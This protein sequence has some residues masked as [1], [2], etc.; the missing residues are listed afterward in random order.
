MSLLWNAPVAAASAAHLAPVSHP[1][2]RSVFPRVV[3]DEIPENIAGQC[4]NADKRLVG[5]RY[6]FIA[7]T[8]PRYARRSANCFRNFATFGAMTIRQ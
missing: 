4:A 8:A 7:A 3:R 6:G 1:A 2:P 5:L